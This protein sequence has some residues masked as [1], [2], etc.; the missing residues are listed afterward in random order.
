[1]RNPMISRVWC[2]YFSEGLIL[3][4]R[5]HLLWALLFLG[6]NAI[7]IPFL[8]E[9]MLADRFGGEYDEYGRH[10]PRVIPRLRPWMP[11]E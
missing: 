7:Y 11:G 6:I 5:P 2:W 1:M 9:P 10:V 8:E 3:L 4:S